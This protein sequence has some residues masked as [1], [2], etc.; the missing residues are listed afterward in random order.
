M[1]IIRKGVN[2][3]GAY[4]IGPKHFDVDVSS[5]GVE[6]TIAL[7]V[8]PPYAHL[9]YMNALNITAIGS[10]EMLPKNYASMSIVART[11][12][13]RVDDVEM[14]TNDSWD[15]YREDYAG[16]DPDTILVG[17]DATDVGIP[18]GEIVAAEA[19]S[20]IWMKRDYDMKL[21]KNA[22]PT[23]ASKI[24]YHVEC[25]YKGHMNE[26]GGF[27]DISLPKMLVIGMTVDTPEVAGY[28]HD[29]AAGGYTSWQA[30]YD[31]LKGNIPAIGGVNPQS[32]GDDLPDSGSTNLKAYLHQGR[33]INANAADDTMNVITSLSG[34][35][36]IYE[37][38][39]GNYVANS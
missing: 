12:T 18:G 21:G 8:I 34:R 14:L 5:D 38:A 23:N 15:N 4:S 1:A 16:V 35:M 39:P 20:N 26:G 13:L 3:I 22:Y 36:D 30:L 29:A 28:S 19:K 10:S 24:R 37:P 25:K 17:T 6:K 32:M 11:V 2:K 31:D 9:G 33:A 27:L 7:F